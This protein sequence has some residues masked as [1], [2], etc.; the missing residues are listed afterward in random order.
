MSGK[1]HFQFADGAM[2]GKA[3]VFD[4]HDTFIFGRAADCHARLPEDDTLVSRHHF[5]VEVN[6]PAARLRDLGSLNGTQVN[7]KKIGGRKKGETPEQG[8]KRRYP[9]I[10]LKDGDQFRVGNTVLQIKTET[11]PSAGSVCSEQVR[12]AMARLIFDLNAADS[13]AARQIVE[14]Q[15]GGYVIEKE[16]GRGGFGAVYRARRATDQQ[17]VAVKVMLP[18]AAVDQTSVDRFLREIRSTAALRHPHIVPVL[19]VGSSEGLFYFVMEY[20][21]GRSLD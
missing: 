17:R 19:D 14:Q 1:V 9:E 11:S 8:A 10:D 16:L 4:E 20:C 5:L 12:E 6:P 18:R 21:A 13:P 3:F 2:K 15:V 7:G